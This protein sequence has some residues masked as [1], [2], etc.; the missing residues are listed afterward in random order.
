VNQLLNGI[1]VYAEN[2]TRNQKDPEHQRY[3]TSHRLQNRLPNQPPSPNQLFRSQWHIRLNPAPLA[4]QNIRTGLLRHRPLA[5][6]L[7]LCQRLI[8]VEVLIDHTAHAGLAMVP[9]SLRAVVPERIFVL[10]LEG[11]DVVGLALCGGEVEAGEDA[12]AVGEGLAGLV[13]G[14][15]DNGV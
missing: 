5:I 13:E 10:H 2:G 9:D 6:L 8:R 12:A 15:L 3:A 11:E 7:V 14:G 1:A 4:L